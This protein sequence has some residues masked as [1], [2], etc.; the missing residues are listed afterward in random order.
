MAKIDTSKING[1]AE[2]TAEQ[3]LAA[4]EAFEYEDGLSEVERLRNAI[5]K[6]NSDAAEWKR[7]HNALLS[8][9]EK[10]KAEEQKVD[11]GFWDSEGVYKEDIQTITPQEVKEIK[12]SFTSVLCT[13]EQK[14]KEIANF[15]CGVCPQ[16]E[17]QCD[18]CCVDL[19]RNKSKGILREFFGRERN[20]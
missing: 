17:G 20:V 15:H 1:Y 6:A 11:V 12:P 10:R 14:I 8:D 16:N 9:D 7:K 18:G 19:L 3:K 4:L 2:M 13:I 5:S